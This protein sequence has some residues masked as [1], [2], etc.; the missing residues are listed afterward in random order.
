MVNVKAW[1]KENYLLITA[2]A[3]WLIVEFM[4]QSITGDEPS[5]QSA[6]QL[7]TLSEYIKYY[8]ET[9]SNRILIDVTAVMVLSKPMIVFKMLNIAVFFL[10]SLGLKKLLLKKQT[11]KIEEVFLLSLLFI[12]PYSCFLDA[13]FS[14]TCIYYLWPVT[15]GVWSIYIVLEKNRTWI[16]KVIGVLLL[17]FSCNMEQ[18]ALLMNASLFLICCFHI[19]NKEKTRYSW[20][21]FLLALSC[22]L[23][24]MNGEG[25]NH[26]VWVEVGNKFPEYI[27]LTALQ[28]FDMGFSTTMKHLVMEGD[29]LWLIFTTLLFLSLA[30]DARF[31]YYVLGA[32]PL[33]VSLSFGLFKENI[34]AVFPP[35]RYMLDSIGEYGVIDLGNYDLRNRWITLFLFLFV[36]ATVIVDLYLLENNLMSALVLIFVFGIGFLSRLI[37]GFSPTIYASG[38]RTYYPLW[39]VLIVL[40]FYLFK[41]MDKK[42]KNKTAIITLLIAFVSVCS[43]ITSLNR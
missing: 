36:L 16:F 28:K 29:P 20:I 18:T 4:I 8:F 43:M 9:W 33:G 1:I 5:Y 35:L 23:F 13:G 22:I 21:M 14:V 42:V 39:I 19:K 17:I 37:M 24:M 7:Q 40:I 10:F 26:R 3:I 2:S 25:G 34:V 15:A 27:G 31:S 32:I 11:D 12:I 38:N 41:K 6:L 30:G